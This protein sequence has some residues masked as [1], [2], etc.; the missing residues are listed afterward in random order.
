MS[1]LLKLISIFTA[2]V[3]PSQ[4]LLAQD[5]APAVPSQT[6]APAQKKFSQAQL[7]QLVAPV[8]LY[9]DGLL[10]QVLAAST[11]PVDIV[12]AA[13]WIKHNPELSQDDIKN[14]LQNKKWDVSVKGMVFF[15]QL[16]A[17]LNDNLDWTKDL[18]D[19]F[20]NQ[21]KDVMDSIQAMR[22]KAKAAGT[23]KTDDKTKVTT[24]SNNNIQIDSADPDT[25]YVQNYVPST[26]YGT[27]NGGG[28][29]YYPD[30]IVAPAWPWP[31]YGG[32][33]CIGFVFA[34]GNG[35]VVY[36]H[37]FWNNY[38]WINP[39]KY[40]SHNLYSPEPNKQWRHD[41]ANTRPI[42]PQTQQIAKQLE[43]EK[44]NFQNFKG[45][46]D[47]AARELRQ[48]VDGRANAAELKNV[49]R[50]L[51]EARQLGADRAF[52]NAGRGELD[53]AFSGARDGDL[54][55]QYG[56]RGYES[57]SFSSGYSGYSGYHYHG[58]GGGFHGGGRR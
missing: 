22:A 14:E 43:T 16:L 33:W 4:F 27:W 42:T 28:S 49:D 2:V 47:A 52:Q 5:A 30:V 34:W 46:N 50:G 11:Y 15:P 19:A 57:R 45:G 10:A 9:P 44:L 35:W 53:H 39:W 36:N 58:G 37:N 7:E 31:W 17:K 38:H 20:L 12:E 8:A 56:D 48:A 23:L 24:D 18:G 29:W 1:R 55:R 6:A 21:Q 54:E 32:S 26:S 40:N 3:L 51:T 41:S 25:V 13:R